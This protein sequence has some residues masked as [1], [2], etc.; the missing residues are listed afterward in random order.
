MQWSVS[1]SPVNHNGA[2]SLAASPK[3]RACMRARLP[4]MLDS[5]SNVLP[6]AI[7]MPVLESKIRVPTTYPAG[8]QREPVQD[9][10]SGDTCVGTVPRHGYKG[11][12]QSSDE[13]AGREKNKAPPYWPAWRFHEPET[14][15]FDRQRQT[16]L[17]CY[18]FMIAV[19]KTS[20]YLPENRSRTLNLNLSRAEANDEPHSVSN[21]DSPKGR[22]FT[23]PVHCAGAR[24]GS[25]ASQRR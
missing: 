11:P 12:G 15:A 25:L 3:S 22:T 18:S 13:M 1:R 8:G 9:T 19:P 21:R 16:E 2:T 7:S 5:P 6:A 17:N 24:P 4:T 14:F 23:V 20:S 10:Q